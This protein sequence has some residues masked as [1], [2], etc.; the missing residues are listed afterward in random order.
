MPVDRVTSKPES[1]PRKRSN[2]RNRKHRAQGSPETESDVTGTY[3]DDSLAPSEYRHVAGTWVLFMLR[4]LWA[5]DDWGAMGEC[6]Q[7]LCCRYGVIT[8]VFIGE[9]ASPKS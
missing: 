9:E 3:S 4:V 8:R 2:S 5:A 1:R 7:G 6:L